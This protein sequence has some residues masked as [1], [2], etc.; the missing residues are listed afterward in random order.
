MIPLRKTL[1]FSKIDLSYLEWNR[2]PVE[3]APK[4]LLL[5]GLADHALVWQDLGNFLADRYHII[6]PDL[7]G[8]GESSKPNQGYSFAAIIA[9][10]EALLH[11][12]QWSC[13]HSLGHSW[14]GKLLPIWAKEYPEQFQSM[15]LVDPI[16]ITRMPSFF[17]LTLPLVYRKLDCLKGMGPFSS[18]SAA[19]SNARQLSQ[20]AEWNELQQ[21]VFQG[22]IEQKQDGTWGSK[23]TIP[24]R[25]Q[26]FEAVL[27]ENGLT[28]M[29]KIP[30]LLIL[31]ERGVNR[32][33][34]QLKPYKTYLEQL[35]I[36]SVPGNHWPFLGQ[37]QSFNPVVEQFLLNVKI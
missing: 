18:R 37:S 13:F 31:P 23:F 7:R 9:D 16:F 27:Q 4:L 32:M 36:Q 19:E 26:I 14:S 21:Q 12:V 11:H 25:N 15:I 5:H 17:K 30:S 6:A 2:A 28:E 1:R 34:W 33:K 10:L 35:T 29:I 22:G 8:H 20:Y 24:A 3:D